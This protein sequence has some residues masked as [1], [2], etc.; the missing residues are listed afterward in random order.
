MRR[1]IG[2]QFEYLEER[3]LL[4][5]VTIENT[6]DL[7][8][9]P[10][11]S[12]VAALLANP[13]DDG[14]SL[15]EA[16]SAAN[17]DPNQTAVSIDFA[18]GDGDA[19]ENSG[20]IVLT[21]GEL[22]ITSELSIN[23]DIDGDDSPDVTIS[24]NNS[25]R[26]FNVQNASPNTKLNGLIL[27]Q[28]NHNTE[29]G[30][31][32]INQSAAT[33]SNS[34]I[35][36]NSAGSFGGAITAIRSQVEIVSSTIRG[37]EA[38]RN[39]G[40]LELVR[41]TT[42]IVSSTIWGNV[43]T[44]DGGGIASLV[45]NSLIITNSTIAGNTATNGF[46]GGVAGQGSSLDLINVTVTGNSASVGGGGL[47]AGTAETLENTIIVGNASTT[48]EQEVWGTVNTQTNSIVSGAVAEIFDE[49]D[50][51][52]GGGVLADNGGGVL[53]VMLKADHTNPALD[54]GGLPAGLLVDARGE[55]R[56]IDLLDLSNGGTVDAGAV[57][58][59]GDVNGLRV[60]TTSIAI[61]PFDG[62]TSLHEA[63]AYANSTTAGPNGDGDADGDGFSNDTITFAS[64]VGEAFENGGSITHSGSSRLLLS[65]DMTINGDVDGDG[66]HD[67]TITGSGRVTRLMHISAGHA[68]LHGLQL[69]NGRAKYFQ[70]GDEVGAIQLDAGA[71][72]TLTSSL[73]SR[74]YSPVGAGALR[75]AG[76]ATIINS[77]F[78]GGQGYINSGGVNNTAG[79][80]NMAGAT[81]TMTDSTFRNN[82]TNIFY[83]GSTGLLLN[84]GTAYLTN[85]TFQ[86]N[87]GFKGGAFQ[88]RSGGVATLAN[89]TITGSESTG[90]NY[91]AFQPAGGIMN[92]AGATLTLTN[93]IVLGNQGREDKDLLNNGTLNL[94]GGNIIGEE[95]SV[96]GAVQQMGITPEDVFADTTIIQ[97]AEAGAV[98]DNGGPVQTVA[99]KSGL[100]NPALDAGDDSEAP[101]A[102]AR[103]E[104]RADH[105]QIANRAGN[106]SDL[107]AYELPAGSVMISSFGGVARASIDVAE[108]TTTIVD[109]SVVDDVD[110]EGSGI[111]Y[112]ISGGTDS[113]LFDVDATTGELTFV[114]AADFEVPTDA[115]RNGIFEVE[116]M[117]SDSDGHTATQVIEV[118]VTDVAETFVVDST[119]SDDDGDYSTGELTLREA[120]NLANIGLTSDDTITFA[121]GTGEAFDNGGSITHSGSRL[122]LSSDMTINGD[123]DGDGDHDIIVTGS[124]RRTKLMHVSAGHA[125]LHGLQLDNGRANYSSNS[126]E[127]GAIQL[128]A[129]AELTL[130]SSLISRAYSPFGVAAIQNAGTATII[131]SEFTGG[132]GYINSGGIN[133]T[134]GIHNMAGATLTMTNSTFRNNL[135]NIFYTGNTG[136]LLND[137]TANLTNVTFQNNRGF[138]GG[139]FQNRPGGVASLTNVTI[140]GSE[141]TGANYAAFQPAGGIMNE[142]GAT[143]TL[144]NSIVLGNQG[145]EDKDL[146]NNGTLNLV[147]GN[148]I[149]E[150]FSVD[151]VV[152]ETGITPEDVFADTTI[153]QGAA[154]GVAADY[155][156]PVQTVALK[157]GLLNPA[158]DAG[159][160]A[161]APSTDARGES[162][163]DHAQISNRAGN[164]SD[165]GAYELPA[166]SVMISSFGGVA[167][168]S[169]EVVEATTAVTDISIVDDVDTEGAGITYSISG[170]SDG[171]LFNVDETTGEVSFAAAPDFEV[172]LDAN[173]NNVYEVEIEA[174]DSD[175]NRATQIVEVT[176]T[177]IAE[178]FVVDNS[179]DEDDGDYSAGEFTLREAVKLTNFGPE[180]ADTIT[181][182]DGTGEAFENE[183]TIRLVGGQIEISAPVDI[184]GDGKVFITADAN[185][186]DVVLTNGQTDV[187][188][189]LASEAAMSD[190]FDNDNDGLIDAA[191]TDGETL[192]DDNSRIFDITNYDAVT[193]MSG[194]TLT[195]GSTNA[196]SEEGGAIRHRSPLYL[197]DS[198]INGNSTRGAASEG[199]G[200]ANPYVDL[201]GPFGQLKLVGSTVDNNRTINRSSGGGGISSFAG[202]VYIKDSSVSG[203]ASTGYGGGV[204]A[205]YGPTTII[206]NSQ[207]NNNTASTERGK[208]GG[209]WSYNAEITDSEFIGNRTM[210]DRGDGGGIVAINSLTID[211]SIV[212]DNH[213]YGIRSDGGGIYMQYAD[214]GLRITNSTITNNTTAGV[215][216]SGGGVY[217]ER[218]NATITG[219]TISGNKTTGR[220]ATGGGV[221]VS[222]GRLT[223]ENSTVTN[224]ATE[225]PESRGGGIRSDSM[226]IR[227][228]VISGNRTLG[229]ESEG[230]GI[231]GVRGF[232]IFDST[233]RDNHTYG[234]EA[235][236]GGISVFGSLN[237]DNSEISGNT[238]SGFDAQ[239]GGAV[240]FGGFNSTNST[241]ANNHTF[242]DESHGGA[243]WARTTS[244]IKNTT[245]TG[246]GTHGS[247][248]DGGGLYLSGTPWDEHFVNLQNSILTGNITSHATVD[249]Y[250]FDPGQWGNELNLTAGNIVGDEF[251]VDGTVIEANL[252]AEEVFATVVD[253]H[254][255]DAGELS[256]NGSSFYTVALKSALLNPALDSGDDTLA[257]DTDIRGEARADHAQMN[258]RDG[259]ISDLG[260]FEL[261]AG[262]LMFSSFAG[263]ARASIDVHEGTTIVTDLAVVDDIDSEGSGV[264]YSI[265][266]GADSLLFN[267]D[268]ST[269]VLNFAAIPDFEI[270]L[271]ADG[272]NLYVVEVKAIDN[273]SYWATQILEVNV[274]DL[275]ETY[276]VDSIRDIDDGDYSSG[277]LTLREA[278]KLAN[279]GTESADTITFAAATGE[280]FEN[281]ATIR[282]IGG[283]LEITAPVTI[284]GDGNV[285]ITADADA[286]D[287]VLAGGITDVDAT[288]ASTAADSDGIDND[289][290]GLIDDADT[291][292]ENLL[293]DN[294]RIFH[295]S[296]ADATTTLSGLTL[297]GG[298][299]TASGDAG[300][301]GAILHEAP[302]YLTDS[303][304]NG[305]S[306]SGFFARG[307]ALAGAYY[308]YAP[309]TITN[310]TLDN[311]RAGNAGGAIMNFA[312]DVYIKDS[313]ISG[314][315]AG[316]RG[317]GILTYFG[318][319]TIIKN[320]KINNNRTTATRGSGGGLWAEFATIS[321]SEFV[322]NRTEGEEAEGGGLSVGRALTLTNTIV[323][324]NHTTGRL[325][326]G[327]GVHMGQMIGGARVEDSIISN[328]STAGDLAGGGGI[329]IQERDTYIIN[330]SITGNRTAGS[331]SPGGG[332]QHRGIGALY[333]EDSSLT[334]NWTEGDGSRGGAIDVNMHQFKNI[335]VTDNETWG[336]Q[337]SG[338][339]LNVGTG[340]ISGSNISNNQTRGYQAFG[341]GIEA[342]RVDLT[343]S[344]VSGNSTLGDKASGGGV[345]ASHTTVNNSTIV[346]NSTAGADALGGGHFSRF[347]TTFFN[348]TVTG[349]STHGANSV[350]GGIYHWGSSSSDRYLALTNSIVLGNTTTSTT[351]SEEAGFGEF[352]E[353]LALTSGN[354]FGEEFSVDG[355]TE[356][357]GVLADYVF[358][359]IADN[360]GVDAGF[361]GDNGGDLPSVALLAAA[362]NPAI[363]NGDNALQNQTLDVRGDGFDRVKAGTIDL[364]SFELQNDAPAITSNGGADTASIVVVENTTEVTNVESS[365]DI[366]SEGAGLVYALTEYGDGGADNAMFELD[367]NSGLL[368]YLASPDYENA[369]DSDADN[370]YEVQV[371]V[372]D[373]VGGR[374][375]QNISVE[376]SNAPELQVSSVEINDGAAQRSMVRDIEV[377]F[378]QPDV[379]VSSDAFSIINTTTG[380]S[381]SPDI[382]SSISG[383]QT[384][385]RLTFSGQDIRGG[386]LTDGNYQLRI[387]ADSIQSTAEL[388]GDYVD[389]FF[390]MF[391]DVDGDRDVDRLD[392]AFFRRAYGQS[393]GGASYDDIF[394]SDNDGDIDRLDY[395]MFRRNYGRRLDP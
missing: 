372:A 44:Q 37:N 167:R 355:A 365:D 384:V 255:V 348:T 309:L 83:T 172:P 154:A 138:K 260:S 10:D 159:N 97:G 42:T 349:N 143:L 222:R 165:L 217:V 24:G 315:I 70:G 148:I 65:S 307:G 386:S 32:R 77:E 31:I 279:A 110:T 247:G 228:S 310:S 140:T 281:G 13:G 156:G 240:V 3:R 26:I 282:L 288:L 11:L 229:V 66:N 303:T 144:T 385:V 149:G 343:G 241:V 289:D 232:S 20:T 18:S 248:A 299:T 175:G 362:S 207:I 302:L 377:V 324:D 308:S 330:T 319:S 353:Q 54:I 206:K 8:N 87:R 256:D 291:D 351:G 213:T 1:A 130:T 6:L 334:G 15:R 39:G 244:T 185:A 391:G 235:F 181:F 163:A 103:G 158:I 383:G 190:G 216:S 80:H 47:L 285:T 187:D 161:D 202:A 22:G 333:V 94:V 305:N 297:T 100:L 246:N 208:G 238:T 335:T 280:A 331:S 33:I 117:A 58:L 7:V 392:Y 219:S 50:A 125:R 71:E 136:I 215:Q 88:N 173:R 242:G 82:L 327:G 304:V 371:T 245:F 2:L 320:T 72:L 220:W 300:W 78:T 312:A 180:S 237:L 170:G 258:N 118:T 76:T 292:G 19:F 51:D 332:I 114:S 277:E 101:T 321:D 370:V 75:N 264:K 111:S 226:T 157:S 295:I 394:D 350:G 221:H 261:S 205:F 142:A 169:V 109:L 253:N 128:D 124:G 179:G 69:D 120:I 91:A 395:V 359:A 116:V 95:F 382:S 283:E 192:L 194:M 49:V 92:E 168:A 262:S 374:S 147:G 86:K 271:D 286:N 379:I 108:N 214:D 122:E 52:T 64:G 218:G 79:I 145:R 390:R 225:G 81:L 270:P 134:A 40:G 28:G 126:D 338:G 363:N 36:G 57:E 171:A 252:T 96:D 211:N 380:Q 344:V 184:Q 314:N 98:A 340:T 189:T 174:I 323:S 155:G 354:I 389:Q 135:T 106:T 197:Y 227:S 186:D 361:L 89:V 30:A 210:G 166:G 46:G 201:Y 21:N 199:G 212:D 376:V 294:S 133:N 195:G 35:E 368:T 278:V 273:D 230:G 346:G 112:S 153:I 150:E 269:G 366:D 152:Q 162:R 105:A 198:I 249:S 296:S 317:G 191:D 113:A 243:V 313:S 137:G 341:G 188:A 276:V 231:A 34:V 263:V 17:A 5:T 139:A 182:A 84:D 141:S 121:S 250:D 357:T 4:T 160:D 164:T 293:D 102:D 104:S 132:Q 393:I 345:F 328:N 388:E 107:G 347:E 316:G 62:V 284:Q 178:T 325:A 239:G 41:G 356:Q 306:T 267:V 322:G 55:S 177:D 9:A 25:S 193:Y 16:I 127:V 23:G 339:G 233:V 67:V 265:S 367:S 123:V 74:G 68:Q 268:A 29:G 209:L 257:E 326:K 204:K 27:T 251:T 38:G 60:D 56:E 272:D 183:A 203:N 290:D 358:A 12:S 369:L 59:V 234:N 200:V 224:N 318:D 151:G 274:V 131:G 14:V 146:L 93:S 176:V 48:G 387:K 61:D 329:Y 196:F 301:G 45:N 254:G 236:G 119:G 287:V 342:F 99:L 115:N 129:G 73:I 378:D 352:S 223:L 266:G 63:I 298:R 259:N 43:A 381:F 337:A 53:T 85:V 373:S 311:N 336:L 375:T 90:A 275:V 360:N 364:G